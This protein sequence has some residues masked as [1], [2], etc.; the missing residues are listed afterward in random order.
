MERL[1]R[2]PAMVFAYFVMAFY[3]TGYAYLL[4]ARG[5]HTE[6]LLAGLIALIGALLM[7]R[8]AE[9]PVR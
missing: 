8:A 1:S 3:S 5:R 9:D 6:A 7:V 4:E 2:M